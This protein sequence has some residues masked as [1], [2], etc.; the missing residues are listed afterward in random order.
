MI[1][2]IGQERWNFGAIAP[3]HLPESW[4]WAEEDIPATIRFDRKTEKA[5]YTHWSRVMRDMSVVK[6][7]RVGHAERVKWKIVERE[8]LEKWAN[9]GKE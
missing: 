9:K 6:A 8:L 2:R 5:T 7:V 3:V 4:S 1:L